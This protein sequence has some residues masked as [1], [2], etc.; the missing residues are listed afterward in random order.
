MRLLLTGGGTAGHVFP[1]IA[2]F[3]QLKEMSKN[4]RLEVL[5]IGSRNGVEQEILKKEKIPSYFIYSGKFRRYFYRS[6]SAFILNIRDIFLL[7]IGFFQAFFA[8]LK[9]QPDI[10]LAKGGYVTLPVILTAWI[11]RI[12]VITHESDVIMGLS[13]KIS[14]RIAK[15]ICLS[16]PVDYYPSLPLNNEIFLSDETPP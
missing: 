4:E 14:A 12:P 5:Y 13:N 10:I 7:G 1:L 16:F 3:D 2:V 15:K 9:Y 6:F 11:C 8:V